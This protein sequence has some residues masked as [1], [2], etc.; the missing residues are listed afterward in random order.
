MLI[1]GKG[2]RTDLRKTQRKF[3]IPATID[4]CVGANVISAADVYSG[5]RSPPSWVHVFYHAKTSNFSP[6]S[7]RTQ[8]AAVA[9]IFAKNL[10][11][12]SFHLRSV[13][14]SVRNTKL[15]HRL[16]EII[17][18]PS[19]HSTAQSHLNSWKESKVIVC[20][21]GIDHSLSPTPSPNVS[22]IFHHLNSC[23][24]LQIL[25]P[26]FLMSVFKNC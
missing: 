5:Q 25:T 21:G 18:P 26:F 24:L 16:V 12:I 17:C 9:Y 11:T 22:M 10:R 1:L 19:F 2:S 6:S 8:A 20:D 7:Q 4:S 23:W 13:T 3:I 15:R 14:S